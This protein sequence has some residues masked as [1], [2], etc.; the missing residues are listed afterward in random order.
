M[1]GG[2]QTEDGHV[3]QVT[4]YLDHRIKWAATNEGLTMDDFVA[5][6]DNELLRIP[7]LGRKTLKHL[8]E[9]YGGPGTSP[10][11]ARFTDEELQTE[12]QRRSERR[13]R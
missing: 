12:L 9:Q 10:D 13:R 3:N 7:N 6:S 4:K 5:L 2:A 1:A 11:L 8:R